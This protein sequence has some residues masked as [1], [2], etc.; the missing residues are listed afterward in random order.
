MSDQNETRKLRRKRELGASRECYTKFFALE[1]KLMSQ[2][3]SAQHMVRS[4]G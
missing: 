3:G 4:V 1:P 2:N